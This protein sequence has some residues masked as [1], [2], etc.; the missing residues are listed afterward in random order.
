MDALGVEGANSCLRYYT[1]MA[2]WVVANSTCAGLGPGHHLLTSA[3]VRARS[4]QPVDAACGCRPGAGFLRPYQ[5]HDKLHV[6]R[7]AQCQTL[8][9]PPPPQ[10]YFKLTAHC[11]AC[12]APSCT[13]AHLQK[14]QISVSSRT[15]VPTDL[16][17][18]AFSLTNTTMRTF[19][20]AFRD[21]PSPPF[22][23]WRWVDSTSPAVFNCTTLG[24]G[25]WGAGQPDSGSSATNQV[26]AHTVHAS[27]AA[28]VFDCS[29][30]MICTAPK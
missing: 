23:G 15:F 21:A 18:V 16:L 25:L 30:G 4:M 3:Q 12:I 29:V 1:T 28:L 5:V 17:S 2:T 7:L 9:V 8:S 13:R 24:C 22:G 11:L 27:L 19:I 20:G 10:F 26:L 6:P 14:A